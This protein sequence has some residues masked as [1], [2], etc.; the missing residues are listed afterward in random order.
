[1]HIVCKVSPGWEYQQFMVKGFVE[2]VSFE[3][4]WKS[5]SGESRDKERQ[6]DV[7]WEMND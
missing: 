7:R 3:P 2:E 4:E 6:T 5:V 1:M